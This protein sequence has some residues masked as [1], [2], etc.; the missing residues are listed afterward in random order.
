MLLVQLWMTGFRLV[1]D[2]R[3][4]LLKQVA[5]AQIRWMHHCASLDPTP[6]SANA[7]EGIFFLVPR[8]RSL[9]HYVIK[10]IFR[11]TSAKQKSTTNSE[12]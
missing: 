11:A 6:S 10:D 1:R 4:K 12:I 2:F 5:V 8:L 9:S 7:V 3:D